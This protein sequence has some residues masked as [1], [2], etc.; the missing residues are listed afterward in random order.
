MDSQDQSQT[1]ADLNRELAASLLRI[2]AE[3]HDLERREQVLKQQEQAAT[4]SVASLQ[5]VM[6]LLAPQPRSPFELAAASAIVSRHLAGPAL[7]GATLSTGGRLQ[8]VIQALLHPSTD[9]V[10]KTTAMPAI[11]VRLPAPTPVVVAPAS[12]NHP[13]VDAHARAAV[14]QAQ[15]AKNSENKDH[16]TLSLL[17]PRTKE[18]LATILDIRRQIKESR[19]KPQSSGDA[20]QQAA[21]KPQAPKKLEQDLLRIL[22]GSTQAPAAVTSSNKDQP[23]RGRAGTFTRKL[24]Q[25][26]EDM[27]KVRPSL[28]LTYTVDTCFYDC[29]TLHIY[30]TTLPHSLDF[31]R[32]TRSTL[33]PF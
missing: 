15:P 26:L 28:L 16:T 20:P 31:Y 22:V 25:M 9:I 30:C 5:D 14:L 12:W 24:H 1:I 6:K 23:P 21:N 3:R 33:P 27:E 19:K 29:I 13:A 10:K 32:T 8:Q 7:G 11:A 18:E 2:M 4:A 17:R